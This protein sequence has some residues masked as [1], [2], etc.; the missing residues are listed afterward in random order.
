MASRQTARAQDS[1]HGLWPPGSWYRGFGGEKLQVANEKPSWRAAAESS[2]FILLFRGRTKHV[3][4][5]EGRHSFRENLTANTHILHPTQR[6]VTL[7]E[8]HS[9]VSRG[10]FGNRRP[11]PGFITHLEVILDQN[12][13][14]CSA[15][16]ATMSGESPLL[17]MKS[18]SLYQILFCLS[19][20]RVHWAIV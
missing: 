5:N 11:I 2:V 19:T 3:G 1:A 16:K 8:S 12:L 7:T 9:I 13:T 15:S 18:M 17:P 6:T 10:N 20:L 14:V 4:W